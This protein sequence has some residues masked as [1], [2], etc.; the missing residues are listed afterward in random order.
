MNGDTEADRD[1]VEDD[2]GKA[3]RD[4]QL[5]E[6]DNHDNR[7]EDGVEDTVEAE[8]FSGDGELA[9]DRQ[10]KK[11]IEFPGSDEFRNIRDVH[12]EKRLEQLRD[13]LVSADEQNHLPF[14]PVA[15]LVDLPENKDRKSTRLNSSH[16]SH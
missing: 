9:V 7:A 16:V 3:R 4:L 15:D 5:R 1:N 10:N 14:R 6:R 12:E 8:L 11:R 13:H 2:H